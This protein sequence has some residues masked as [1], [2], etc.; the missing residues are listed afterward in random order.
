MLIFHYN[1]A[2]SIG[3]YTKPTKEKLSDWYH[4]TLDR[5]EAI[6]L[7]HQNGDLD[8]SFLVRLSERHEGIRV[9][10]VM[11]NKQPY[12]FQIQKR[13]SLKLL[14]FNHQLQ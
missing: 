2:T 7:L 1:Y 8:G 5:M 9:L 13:V 6:N 12:H 14:R 10:T 3:N 11:Y 4:G